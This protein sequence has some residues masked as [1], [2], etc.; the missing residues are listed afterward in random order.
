MRHLY[1]EHGLGAENL[2]LFLGTGVVVPLVALERRLLLGQG[3][4]LLVQ[5]GVDNVGSFL[6][7][8]GQAAEGR[9]LQYGHCTVVCPI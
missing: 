2:E 8:E 5:T 6:L 9:C 3:A 4:R 7:R 1:S